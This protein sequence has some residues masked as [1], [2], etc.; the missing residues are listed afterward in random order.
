M[1]KVSVSIVSLEQRWV[2]GPWGKSLERNLIALFLESD[3]L[4]G[5]RV[6]VSTCLPHSWYRFDPWH[7]IIVSTEH[8]WIW[9]QKQTNE[10]LR[11]MKTFKSGILVYT[12]SPSPNIQQ[13]KTQRI[14]TILPLLRLPTPNW[15][16]S[17]PS[18]IAIP[19]PV[20]SIKNKPKSQFCQNEI[21][22]TKL[23]YKLLPYFRQRLYLFYI[24]SYLFLPLGSYETSVHKVP[25]TG[26]KSFAVSL[27]ETWEY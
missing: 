22:L 18:E 4:H 21:Y 24:Y 12:L 16:G 2:C 11:D 15:K 23:S 7:K 5:T 8:Y 26:I 14:A 27:V 3:R 19:K 17:L 10:N 9:H 13:I 6:I 20:S 1:S 25:R